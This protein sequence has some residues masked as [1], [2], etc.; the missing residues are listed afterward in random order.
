MGLA[1]VTITG[2][3]DQID[4]VKLRNL[5]REFPFVEWGILFSPKREGYPRYPSLSW[6]GHAKEALRDHRT[7][8]HLCGD[9]ARF[10]LQRSGLEMFRTALGFGRVQVNGYGFSDNL[11]GGGPIETCLRTLGDACRWILQVKDESQLAPAA[12]IARPYARAD[13][14]YDP[15]GGQGLSP[16]H[17][18]RGA[19]LR[20]NLGYAG[21]IGPENVASV[22]EELRELRSIGTDPYWIDMESGVRS[23]AAPDDELDLAKV[24][25]VLEAARPFVSAQPFGLF[26]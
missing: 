5:S 19:G 12:A 9:A 20:V 7:A 16:H 26:L 24:R 23:G 22:V 2:A 1:C 13:L 10:P 6:I 25:A 4:P 8:A 3:D 11:D 21:G 15:S 17:W 14:L 18:P